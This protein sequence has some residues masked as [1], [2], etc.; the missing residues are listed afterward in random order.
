[1]ELDNNIRLYRRLNNWKR[2]DLAKL[3]GISESTLYKM[4]KKDVIPKIT[5]V[6]KIAEVLGIPLEDVYFKPDNRP[7]IKI[8]EA[9]L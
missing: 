1:M 6:Y 5:T 9:L 4:E 3:V 2:G 8:P 7:K